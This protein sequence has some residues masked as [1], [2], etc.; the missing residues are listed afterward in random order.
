VNRKWGR[1]GNGPPPPGSERGFCPEWQ[2]EIF[3]MFWA[4]HVAHRADELKKAYRQK[5]KE[6]HPDRN[7]DNPNAE[8]QFKEVNEAYDVLKDADQARP[9]MTVM[10]ML[11]L[12]AAA[13]GAGRKALAARA[14]AI[15]PAPFRTCSKTCSAISWVA[16]AADREAG[17]LARSADRT[18]AITCGYRW[19]R[20]IRVYRKRSTCPH[21]WPA[22]P[23]AAPGPRA[24]QNP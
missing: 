12:K 19:K 21:R 16:R 3:T 22:T 17:G 23:V 9:P 18:C 15:S 1:F 14:M 7:S 11:P 20:P 8:A 10:A 4:W 2:N 5:A 24:A 13:V 6:L